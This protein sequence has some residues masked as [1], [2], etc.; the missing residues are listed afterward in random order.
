MSGS[1]STLGK[2]MVVESEMLFVGAAI[3]VVAMW[4]LLPRLGG[5]PRAR[6]AGIVLGLVSLVILS[7]TLPW[8]GGAAHLVITAFSGITVVSA[9]AAVTAQKPV[10]SA[11]WFGLTL[12]GTSGLFFVQGAQ[13]LAVA[14]VVVYAGAILV[15]FLFV[16]LLAQAEGR[17]PYDRASTEALV[18]AAAGGAIVVVLSLVL[19]RVLALPGLGERVASADQRAAVVLNENHVAALGTE[20][21]TRHLVAVEVAGLLLLVALVAAAAITSAR[22]PKS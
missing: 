7:A 1:W 8:L 17:T 11:V 21:F 20:L 3:G 12:L 13:F 9:T 6:H 14:T 16:L 19:G 2:K 10:Y 18:S 5:S 15:M 22:G 4:L